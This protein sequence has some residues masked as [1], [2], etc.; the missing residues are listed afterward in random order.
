MAMNP[1][2]GYEGDGDEGDG[3]EGD[4]GEE[5]AMKEMAMNPICSAY[6]EFNSC[7]G[8]ETFFLVLTCF[9]NRSPFPSVDIMSFMF[10]VIHLLVHAK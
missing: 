9:S 1:M 8:S 4:G 6:L 10:S 2:L 7:W 3:D 5:M